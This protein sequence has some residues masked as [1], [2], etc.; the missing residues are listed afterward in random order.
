MSTLT[1]DWCRNSR[2][3][4]RRE[5]SRASLIRGVKPYDFAD[6]MSAE[7]SSLMTTASTSSVSRG[8]PCRAAATPPM[9]A[10]RRSLPSNHLIKSEIVARRWSIGFKSIPPQY[11]LL[12]SRPQI[13]R[14]VVRRLPARRREHPGGV[15][16]AAQL[17]KLLRRCHLPG[18]GSLAFVH[19]IPALHPCV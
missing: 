10:A 18:L 1:P 19:Q 12:Q 13:S 14:C 15:H 11:P 6:S 3:R 7:G 16:Q 5:K 2:T 9:T 8:R 17:E 4:V